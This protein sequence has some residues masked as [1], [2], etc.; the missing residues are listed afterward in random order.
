M[1]RDPRDL[2]KAVAGAAGLSTRQDM[3]GLMAA[4]QMGQ[5]LGA[6]PNPSSLPRDPALFTAP[7]VFAPLMPATTFPIDAPTDREG[8][9]KIGRAH[10]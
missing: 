3:S 6:M 10:V 7:G 4:I 2:L 1:P 5:S 9:P 8:G